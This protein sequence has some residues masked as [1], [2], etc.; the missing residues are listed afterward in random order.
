MD[1]IIPTG[2]TDMKLYAVRMS[3]KIDGWGLAYVR[4]GVASEYVPSIVHLSI[5]DG[6]NKLIM[7]AYDIN[8]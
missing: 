3:S 8:K 5:S 7:T 2:V 1:I 6:S 4:N